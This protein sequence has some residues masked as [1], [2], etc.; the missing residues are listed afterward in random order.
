[1]NRRQP[2]TAKDE[3]R[4][5]SQQGYSHCM[6]RALCVYGAVCVSLGPGRRKPRVNRIGPAPEQLHIGVDVPK[7]AELRREAARP[8]CA[9]LRT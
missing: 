1:M 9:M 7:C 5:E 2:K 4:K 3:D 8:M 6:P